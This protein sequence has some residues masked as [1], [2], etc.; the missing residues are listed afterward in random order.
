MSSRNRFVCLQ[1]ATMVREQ[2]ERNAAA[3]ASGDAEWLRQAQ[4]VF[5]ATVSVGGQAVAGALFYPRPSK[6]SSGTSLPV[7]TLTARAGPTGTGSPQQL[8]SL[9]TTVLHSAGSKLANPPAAAA[10]HVYVELLCSNSPGRGYGSLLLRRIEGFVAQQ[11][12]RLE[13][14]HPGAGRIQGV[15]LLSV[16]SAQKFYSRMGYS[17]PDEHHEM[18]KTLCL[19]A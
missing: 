18:S 14:C 1:L 15:R 9:A 8:S 10:A 6:P 7:I 19:C 12:Q 2:C 17:E 11:V 3:A 16:S 13:Q 4:Y 5:L